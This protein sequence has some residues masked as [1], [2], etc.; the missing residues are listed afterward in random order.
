[1]QAKRLEVLI[2]GL[3]NNQIIFK[4][5]CTEKFLFNGISD[6]YVFA[7]ILRTGRILKQV[8]ISRDMIL[9]CI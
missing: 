2:Y 4:L 9:Q 8:F 5:F 7:H 1:M 3:G 6:Y